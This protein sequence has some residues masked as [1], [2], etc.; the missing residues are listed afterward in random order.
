MTMM[1]VVAMFSGCSW[2]L[3]GS[4]Q[5]LVVVLIASEENAIWQSKVVKVQD[6]SKEK[7][8]DC[9]ISFPWL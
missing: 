7:K 8:N 2:Y 6:N 4:I 1:I 9:T 3:F 5:D